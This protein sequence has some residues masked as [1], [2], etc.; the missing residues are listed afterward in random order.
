MPSSGKK[1]KKAPKR[2]KTKGKVKSKP[3]RPPGGVAGEVRVLKDS[4]T[5]LEERVTDLENRLTN[6][7]LLVNGLATKVSQLTAAVRGAVRGGIQPVAIIGD[8]C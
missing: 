6:L 5:K 8:E 7:E 4:V 2:P 1:K 3:M